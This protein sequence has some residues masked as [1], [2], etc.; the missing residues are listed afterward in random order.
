MAGRKVFQLA[1]GAV[2]A[3]PRDLADLAKTPRIDDRREPRPRVH[4]AAPMLARDLFRT[5]HLLGHRPP[6]GEFV[7]FLFPAHGGEASLRCRKR[8][9]IIAETESERASW[10][11]RVGQY[12]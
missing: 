11:E 3:P 2:G 6:C 9:A 12:V 8:H 1:I 7:H 5:A 4:L 10:R